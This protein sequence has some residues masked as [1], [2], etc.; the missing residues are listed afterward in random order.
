MTKVYEDGCDEVEDQSLTEPNEPRAVFH[1]T[2][3]YDGTNYLGWQVQRHGNTIQGELQRAVKPIGGPGC[4][5]IGSGRTDSGVHA[6]A[7]VAR[8]ILPRWNETTDRL[9]A[10]INSRLPPDILV[11]EVR[12]VVDDF[13][14]IHH[15]TAKTYRYQVQVGGDS[16]VFGHRFVHRIRGRQD[17]DRLQDAAARLI[18]RHDFAAFQASGAERLTTVRTL[19][20]SGWSIGPSMVPGPK[21]HVLAYEVRGDGFL[22]NMVRNLVGTMLDIGRGRRP[23]EWIDEVLASRDR[24]RAGMT[25]AA[26]GLF[27]CQ[28]EYPDDVFVGE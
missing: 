20:K 15:A 10:A 8:C 25:A 5:V 23:P 3:A 12:R 22:Y 26:R 19:F 11:T 24:G 6:I 18:G 13:H 27:L 4:R 17:L 1:L 9:R 21:E 16:D 2:I 7:Q 14:P 28:V